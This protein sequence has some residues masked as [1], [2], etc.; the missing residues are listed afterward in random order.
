MAFKKLEQP[1]VLYMPP[2]ALQPSGVKK[3][4]VCGTCQMFSPH[5]SFCSILKPS[6]VNGYTGV[7][8]LYVGGT[9]MAEEATE[10]VSAKV[11]G[12]IDKGAPTRCGTCRFFIPET[13]ECQIVEGTVEA[14]GCCHAWEPFGE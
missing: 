1:V 13:K 3:G 7:C 2:K 10:V 14:Y 8:G 6:N 5:G 12:Y 4:A 11:A 9:P